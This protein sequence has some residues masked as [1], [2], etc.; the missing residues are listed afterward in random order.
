[1]LARECERLGIV[2]KVFPKESFSKDA[3]SYAAK[4]ANGP[5]NAFGRM[6]KNLHSGMDQSLEESLRL[7][8]IHLIESMND[9]ESKEAIQAF[10][11]KRKPVFRE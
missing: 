1:M 8:A 2:N 3:Q 7:E 6:K 5:V 9:P 10:M 11:E 4:V